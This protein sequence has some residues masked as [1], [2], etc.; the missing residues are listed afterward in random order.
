MKEEMIMVKKEEYQKL[1]KQ[2]NI[3]MEFLSNL[4]S[5][6]RDIKEGRVRRVK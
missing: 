6:L 1:K 2:A 5:S 4:I 3:D